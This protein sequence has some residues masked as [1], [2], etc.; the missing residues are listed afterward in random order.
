MEQR[1]YTFDEKVIPKRPQ[2]ITIASVNRLQKITSDKLYL[3]ATYVT[4]TGEIK[5]GKA[6]RNE[7]LLRGEQVT[8]K[9]YV[10]HPKGRKDRVYTPK[11]KTEK[12]EKPIVE[13]VDI[14]WKEHVEEHKQEMEQ[15][16]EERHKADVPWGRENYLKI[17]AEMYGIDSE[18][19]K[20]WLKEHP[21]D[22]D[23]YK[24][25][26]D[27][28]EHQKR[29]K[30]EEQYREQ[31]SEGQLVYDRIIEV[32]NDWRKTGEHDTA[33]DFIES[34][35]NEAIEKTG[36]NIAMKNLSEQLDMKMSIDKAILYF[37][38]EKGDQALQ[39]ILT[40][41]MQRPLTAEENQHFSTLLENRW[42]D[43]EEYNYTG[44]ELE[45][46]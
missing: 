23:Y 24:L 22:E 25:L 5:H 13:N 44:E 33:C 16:R 28:Y 7:Q 40:A 38:R 12:E 9:E 15:R 42:S 36:K 45:F 34:R 41:I 31:F 32:I 29:L 17:L 46:D 27:D 20:V 39:E 19:V 8:K 1:G 6:K 30:Q 11:P 35:I 2:K 37:G 43:A 26:K 3:G 10:K 18:Q 14:D 4:S 21:T